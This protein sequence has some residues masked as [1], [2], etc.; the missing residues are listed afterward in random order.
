MAKTIDRWWA[1]AVFEFN[2]KPPRAQ[3]GELYIGVG[4]PLDVTQAGVV[5]CPKFVGSRARSVSEFV[6]RADL[7]SLQD[8][9]KRLPNG[10][11]SIRR[12]V[13]EDL[14][15]DSCMALL[16]WT[17]ALRSP[18]VAA[19][20]SHAIAWGAYATRWETGHTRNIDDPKS[21][22][23]FLVT[24]LGHS[25][26]AENSRSDGGV[27]PV[28]F[29]EGA[30]ACVELLADAFELSR[31]PD[32]LDVSQ[33]EES[34]R[35]ARARAHFQFEEAAYQRVLEHAHR[36]Q[37]TVPLTGSHRSMLIDALFLEEANPSGL[38][39]AFARSDRANSWTHRGFDML[40]IFRPRQAGSGGDMTISVAPEAGLTLVSLWQELERL[41]WKH[42][43]GERPTDQPRSIASYKDVS[44]APNEPWW[45]DAGHY[46]LLGAPKRIYRGGSEMLGSK[47]AWYEHVLPAVWRCYSPIPL[48]PTLPHMQTIEIGTAAGLARSSLHASDK[49]L[50]HCRWQN[51]GR[52]P[53]Q[54]SAVQPSFRSSPPADSPTLH[55]WLASVSTRQGVANSPAGLMPN[56]SFRLVKLDSG[57]VVIH[58]DGAT[59]FEDSTGAGF[60]LTAVQ[61]ILLDMAEAWQDLTRFHAERSLEKA[62]EYQSGLLDKRATFRFGD[63]ERWKAAIWSHR[64][65][66]LRVGIKMSNHADPWPM[67]ELRRQVTMFWGFDE[68]RQAILDTIEQ[69]DR[70]T[71]EIATHLRERRSRIVQAVGAGL[72]LGIVAKEVAETIRWAFVDNAYAFQLA[73]FR[74]TAPADAINQL[75][76][77]AHT[78]HQ[79]EMINIGALA[80]GLVGGGLLYLRL[81]A[82]PTE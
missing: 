21:S 49:R 40:G 32:S 60:D 31:S 3:D 75:A 43:N 18:E 26:L 33:L 77:A 64:A 67:N 68:H 37:L 2:S 59:V 27:D 38:L 20:D 1:H 70:I 74:S 54:G 17:Q 30:R 50:W 79:W 10:V 16:L 7:A 53:E 65:K 48:D 47:L 29:A 35:L 72:A 15:L 66:A 57:S 11:S 52:L 55:A 13:L 36:C 4:D 6:L 73:L 24:V 14:S 46:T 69:I 45:D 81:G 9:H 8:W 62:L 39:K 80:V 63:F 58:R 82:K 25:Y 12:I 22:L 28:R 23:A 19:F 61:S 71:S 5:I 56:Q 44:P 78:L 34:P 42:W 51:Q 76:D 41:E